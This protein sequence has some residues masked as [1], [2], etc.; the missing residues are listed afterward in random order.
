MHSFIHTS[1]DRQREGGDARLFRFGADGNHSQ[2]VR[3]D[4]RRQRVEPGRER[5]VALL[6]LHL[7]AALPDSTRQGAGRGAIPPRK[8][9]RSKQAS[10]KERKKERKSSSHHIL[11]I[12]FH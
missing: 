3:R 6:P 8:E 7:P 9:G 12:A 1:G 2:R 11:F 4:G 10:T 5:G